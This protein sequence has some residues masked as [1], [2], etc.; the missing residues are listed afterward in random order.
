M[1][2]YGSAFP[3]DKVFYPAPSAIVD[4]AAMAASTALARASTAPAIG[5]SEEPSAASL[6]VAD[7]VQQD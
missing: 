2:G 1:A 3:G 6:A 5:P 4:V 7:E